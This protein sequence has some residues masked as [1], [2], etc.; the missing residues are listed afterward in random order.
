MIQRSRLTTQAPKRRRGRGNRDTGSGVEEGA[1][2]FK[3]KLAPVG[4][5]GER[6]GG[7]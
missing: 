1:R 4:G 2:F 3:K 5:G 7:C 6:G